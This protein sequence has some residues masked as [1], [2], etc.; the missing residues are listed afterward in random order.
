VGVKID[1]PGNYQASV[2]LPHF[3]RF[4]AINGSANPWDPAG[5]KRQI[6]SYVDTASGIEDAISTKN[7]VVHFLSF[8]NRPISRRTRTQADAGWWKIVVVVED[9][10]GS[11]KTKHLLCK[12]AN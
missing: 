12:S 3:D 9:W 2:N 4:G 8:F 10:A 11:S 5:R 6:G 7:Q 1:Q